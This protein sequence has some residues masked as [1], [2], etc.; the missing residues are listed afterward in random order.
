MLV[1]QNPSF[2]SSAPSRPRSPPRTPCYSSCPV[3]LVS[4]A[5]ASQTLLLADDHAD[6]EGAVRHFA[7]SPSA[8]SF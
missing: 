8:E 4:A 2:F 7:E 1:P 5:T 6:K 3:S